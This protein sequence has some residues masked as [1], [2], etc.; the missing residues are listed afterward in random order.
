MALLENPLNKRER[1]EKERPSKP[2]LIR[3]GFLQKYLNFY[4]SCFS[5]LLPLMMTMRKSDLFFSFPIQ[6]YKIY[7]VY[8]QSDFVCNATPSDS[9]FNHL[10]VQLDGIQEDRLGRTYAHVRSDTKNKKQPIILLLSSRCFQ[11]IHS[12]LAQHLV[13]L[14]THCSPLPKTDK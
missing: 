11:F 9:F 7:T 13:L 14:S 6:V 1:T 3:L 12:D 2:S 8:I 5:L 4:S 10:V